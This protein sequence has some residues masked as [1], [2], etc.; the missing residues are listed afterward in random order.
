[1]TLDSVMTA[2]MCWLSFLLSVVV[3]SFV[4]SGVSERHCLESL[5]SEMIC[6]VLSGML[7]S[8]SFALLTR[9]L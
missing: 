9:S 1:M 3:S 6:Y 2:N 4:S 8:Y 5:I 7:N